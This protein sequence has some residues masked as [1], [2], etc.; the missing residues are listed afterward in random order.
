MKIKNIAQNKANKY[1][2]LE[3]KNPLSKDISLRKG[4][5]PQQQPFLKSALDARRNYFK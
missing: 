3:A 1:A 5:N 4:A 2:M